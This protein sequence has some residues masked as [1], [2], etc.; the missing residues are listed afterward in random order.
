MKV[1][2]LMTK[3]ISVADVNTPIKQVAKKMKDLNV[4]SIPVCDSTNQPVGI[5]TDRD[6][7]TRCVSDGIKDSER[8]QSI[9]SRDLVC[10]S[11]DTHIHEAS[12]IM[13]ENQIRRLP[14]VENKKIVGMISIG[15]LTD[16]HENEAG[17][18]LGEISEQSRPLG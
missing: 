12:R 7:A 4:G 14:V 2:D 16:T 5:I 11:P 15:D 8:A 9:M 6:I 13:G 1:K 17:K 3:H 18:A 10:V